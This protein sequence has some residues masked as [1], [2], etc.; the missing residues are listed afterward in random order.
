MRW[1]IFS[2]PAG[3]IFYYFFTIHN[4]STP[5]VSFADSSLKEGA[6]YCLPL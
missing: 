1:N 5:S 4:L 3:F 6:G 2:K